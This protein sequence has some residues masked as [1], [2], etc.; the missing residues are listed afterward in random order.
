[1]AGANLGMGER[2]VTVV[3][4]LT[5]AQVPGSQAEKMPRIHL[6]TDSCCKGSL[7]VA[8]AIPSELSLS[9]LATLLVG[10]TVIARM[11]FFGGE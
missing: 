2:E 11:F 4:S 3:V 10:M 8:A 6:A 9:Y 1:M 7:L 5:F